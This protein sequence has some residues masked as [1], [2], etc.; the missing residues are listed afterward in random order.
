MNQSRRPIFLPSALLRGAVA[1]G[2]STIARPR[3]SILRGDL[4]I[5]LEPA[6]LERAAPASCVARNSF[7][8]VTVSVR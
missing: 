4:V 1:I 6:G 5:E 7:K 2:T 8:A 3:A